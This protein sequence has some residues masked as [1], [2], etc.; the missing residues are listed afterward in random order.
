M[1]DNFSAT[2]KYCPSKC[3]LPRNDNLLFIMEYTNV[4]A[5]LIIRIEC[6]EIIYMS[7]N[8]ISFVYSVHGCMHTLK[9]T[10]SVTTYV[11]NDCSDHKHIASIIIMVIMIDVICYGD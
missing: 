8:D 10:V 9:K 6:D 7:I 4:L 3:G 5:K 11:Y 1:M 2:T